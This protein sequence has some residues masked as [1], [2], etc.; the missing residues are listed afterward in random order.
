[1][2]P[3][4]LSNEALTS[5]IEEQLA[6][7]PLAAENFGRLRQVRRRRIPLGDLDSAVQ[8]NPARI[9]STGAS[10]DKASI[11]ARPCFLCEANRPAEQISAEWADGWH[12]LVNPYPILPVHFTIADKEHR[13]QGAIPLDMAA[14]AEASPDMVFFYN[15]A[16]AGA[17]APDH[18]HVQAVLA[19]E[20]P[21]LCLAEKIHP[22]ERGTILFSDET[23][24]DLPFHFVSA[25]ITP[26]SQGMR[27]LALMPGAF[28]IDADTNKPDH[29]LLNAFFRIDRTGLLRIVIVPR[30]R[31][32]PA[33]YTGDGDSR[34]LVSP[35][36]IDM[37][38]LMISPRREDFDKINADIMRSI[39]AEV[40]FADSLPATIKN[41]FTI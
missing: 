17:S 5:F 18:R 4:H 10:V 26:D 7:W 32:R 39:Y 28:G 40:A 34:L 22:S 14:M 13:P 27:T 30:R 36:A 12:L 3:A 21:L 20:L 6:I 33:C 31:H 8:C 29:G 15:G 19:E 23:D 37:T 11:A 2:Q 16:R 41:Y 38:G 35:G 24:A 1:M 9:V 25:V